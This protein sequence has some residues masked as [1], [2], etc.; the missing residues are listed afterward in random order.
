M[1]LVFNLRSS[2]EIV[3]VCNTKTLNLR[4]RCKL[5]NGRVKHR[6]SDEFSLEEHVHA[7]LD[8]YPRYMFRVVLSRSHLEH[9]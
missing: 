4:T 9:Y 3:L 6:Q 5:L 2:L 8:P 7:P 1:K